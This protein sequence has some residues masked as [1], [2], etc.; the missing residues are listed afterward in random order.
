MQIDSKYC[1]Y[2]EKN[3]PVCGKR[4]IPA[5]EHVYKYNGWYFCSYTCDKQRF[6]FKSKKNSRREKPVVQFDEN[7][8]F[9]A[10][11]DSANEAERTTLVSAKQ[12]RQ[13]CCKATTRKRAGG[14]YWEYEEGAQS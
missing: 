4:F 3:C 1:G 12:I 7:H 10:R 9:V 14:F 13:C 11:Y 5:P 6:K 8:L 2:F